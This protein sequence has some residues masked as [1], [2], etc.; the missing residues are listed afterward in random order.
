MRTAAKVLVFG[1]QNQLRSR[2]IL[3]Y[4]LLFL[5]L[6]D[7]LFRFGGSGPRVVV[8]LLN[9]VL[10][11][12]PLVSVVFGTLHFSN[13]REF[14][15]LLLA[16]P[17]GRGALYVGLYLGLALPLAAAYALGIVL[18]VLWHG[19][20]GTPGLG[21]LLAAGVLLTFVFTSL[22]FLAGVRFD[23]RAKGLGVALL[24]WFAATVLYDGL[25]LL[26]ATLFA[27]YPLE[28]PM[29]GF[30]LANPIDLAR[31]LLLLRVDA[32]ALM[33]YTGAV[34][35]RFFGSSLGILAALGALLLWTVLPFVAGL[36][37]FRRKDF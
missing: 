17:V 18:P 4:G 37:G 33:G 12:V 31:V 1:L 32:A 23:D 11:V 27:D 28:A 15:E 5:L 19:G 10:L 24:A 16:Q 8:S 21:V 22:A 20:A 2:W 25:V 36:A 6:T 26:A 13:S 14:I 30:A 35:E 7:A 34:F 29:L 9:V 3:G